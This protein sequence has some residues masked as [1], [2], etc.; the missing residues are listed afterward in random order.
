MIAETRRRIEQDGDGG[1]A[2]L[3]REVDPTATVRPLPTAVTG[4][5]A[6][7]KDGEARG[8][9][10]WVL[11]S[12]WTK[13]P[14]TTR[15]GKGGAARV[16]GSHAA[17]DVTADAAAATAAT[18]DR[19]L[20]LHGGAYFY[21]SPS[22]GYRPLTTRLAAR[23]GLPVLAIDYRLAPEHPFP[24]AVVDAIAALAWIRDNGPDGA[25][26]ARRVFLCGDSA[27]GGLA[28]A[29]LMARHHPEGLPDATAKLAADTPLVDGL[30]A[31]SPYTDLTCSLPSYRTRTY[32]AFLVPAHAISFLPPV[33]S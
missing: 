23:T 1:T 30:I 26:P 11:P 18:T 22:D 33:C 21:F 31:L 2:A 32:V 13:P 6:W 24:A 3:D 27:G 28:L 7:C 10:E 25:A 20:F 8:E 9:A 19:I 14:P 12:A 17:A 29:A 15:V 4:F 5:A 16:G